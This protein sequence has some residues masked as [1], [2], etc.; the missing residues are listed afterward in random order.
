MPLWAA[1]PLCQS[2][3]QETHAPNRI[4]GPQGTVTMSRAAKLTSIN[5]TPML[6]GQECPVAALAAEAAQL[7]RALHAI[8]GSNNF[9]P[10]VALNVPALDHLFD[11]D[12]GPTLACVQANLRKRLNAIGEFAQ[13]RRAKSIK[14]ALFQLYVAGNDAVCIDD[15]IFVEGENHRK[16]RQTGN[17]LEDL[18]FSALGAL[19][20]GSD[21]DLHWLR[22]WFFPSDDY[23]ASQGETVL[24]EL[25]RLGSAQG[26]NPVPREPAA[27]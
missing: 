17:R 23:E 4:V 27:V 3:N 9:L 26:V 25:H 5:P 1:R 18:L 12:T 7:V 19:D 2:I 6:D 10:K 13:F 11:N 8:A 20:G 14:G 21:D 15:E 16:L 22:S 24:T